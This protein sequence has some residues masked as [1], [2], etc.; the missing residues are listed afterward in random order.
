MAFQNIGREMVRSGFVRAL[1]IAFESNT[2][3]QYRTHP[4]DPYQPA[5]DSKVFI[6]DAWPWKRVSYPSIVISLGGGDPMMRTIGGEYKFDGATTDYVGQ[7]G[8]THTT[9]DAETYG[10]GIEM[11]VRINVFA[12]SAIERSKLMD[13]IEI[14]IRHFFVGTFQKEGVSIVGMSQG[15]ESQILVGADPVY[16]DSVDV[17][18]YSEFERTIS[19]A[20]SGTINAMCLTGIFTMLNDGT[21]TDC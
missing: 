3:F 2:D 4:L 17:T 14:Y 18:V 11:T 12:R 1:R 8:L 7:D 16:T 9:V 10:G 6:Y 13:W 5:D 19:T 21:T 15:G 20:T